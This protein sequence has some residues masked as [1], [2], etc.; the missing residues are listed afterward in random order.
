MGL[1]GILDDM[2]VITRRELLDR[3]QVG[4]PPVE[5]HGKNGAS[6]GR[7]QAFG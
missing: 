1:S 5:V 7:D 4:C 6:L 2:E 3:G